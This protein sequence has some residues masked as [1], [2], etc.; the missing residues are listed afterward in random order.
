MN[1][2][3]TLDAHVVGNEHLASLCLPPI[4]GTT[5]IVQLNPYQGAGKIV[6]DGYLEMFQDQKT[7]PASFPYKINRTEGDK[8][9]YRFQEALNIFFYFVEG[10]AGRDNCTQVTRIEALPDEIEAEFLGK[11]DETIDGLV[12]LAATRK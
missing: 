10:A 3:V 5:R 8:E 4:P 6:Y 1:Y 9:I 2:K 7:H 12:K 11:F